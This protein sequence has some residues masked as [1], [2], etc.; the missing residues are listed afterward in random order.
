MK[1]HL[2]FTFIMLLILTTGANAATTT[3]TFSDTC[4]NLSLTGPD[5]DPGY[6]YYVDASGKNNRGNW[7]WAWFYVDTTLYNESKNP[8]QPIFFH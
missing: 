8:Q 6:S 7:Y 4:A 3:V 2:L 5:V 1:R